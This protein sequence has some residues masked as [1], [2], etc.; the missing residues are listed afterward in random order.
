MNS[1]GPSQTG[2]LKIICSV[3][4]IPQTHEAFSVDKSNKN[5]RCCRCRQ[6]DKSRNEAYRQANKEKRNARLRAWREANKTSLLKKRRAYNEANKSRINEQKKAW[7][8]ANKSKKNQWRKA[9]YHRHLI[10]MREKQRVYWQSKKIQF[11][12]QQKT[13]QKAKRDKLHHDYLRNLLRKA[14]TV[15]VEK[16]PTQFL[17]LKRAHLLV[18]REIRK[19]THENR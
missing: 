17:E 6:C 7:D 1:F 3:C 15:K 14:S 10:R 19:A 12:E 2:E 16:F 13:Y 8:K 11:L 5:G 18:L 9:Y 4:K